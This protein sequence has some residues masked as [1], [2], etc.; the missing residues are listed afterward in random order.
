MNRN[1]DVKR[2]GSKAELVC[3]NYT[4]NLCFET[5]GKVT[6]LQAER[7]LGFWASRLLAKLAAL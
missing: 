4:L 6:L 1:D 7:S 5:K 2:K 3:T